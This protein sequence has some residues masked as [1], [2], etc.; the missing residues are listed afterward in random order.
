LWKG[1][2][3]PD[4][5]AAIGPAAL[6]DENLSGS[7]C[8]ASAGYNYVVF[9]FGAGPV[10]SSRGWWRPFIWATWEIRLVFSPPAGRFSS[11]RVYNRVPDSDNTAMFLGTALLL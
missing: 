9:H 1:A 5:P 6:N 10:G 4:F 2:F 7:T 8:A 3:N 11:A